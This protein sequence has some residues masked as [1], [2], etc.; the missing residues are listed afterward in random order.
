MPGI[1]LLHFNRAATDLARVV[2]TRPNRLMAVRPLERC[3]LQ[4]SASGL[5]IRNG[6]GPFTPTSPRKGRRSVKRNPDA[7]QDDA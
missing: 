1:R 5:T 3:R 6:G 2:L 7:S 4:S